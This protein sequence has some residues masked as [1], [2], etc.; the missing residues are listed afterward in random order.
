MSDSV[1]D[2][3]VA[4][5][6]ISPARRLRVQH[7]PFKAWVGHELNGYPAGVPLPAYRTGYHGLASQGRRESGD[8][9]LKR[10]VDLAKLGWEADLVLYSNGTFITG[11]LIS[12]V[13][14]RAALAE[15]IRSGAGAKPSS[16]EFDGVVAAAVAAEDPPPMM[17]ADG[18]MPEPRFVHLADVRT[19]GAKEP[20]APFMR[21]RLPAVSG[22]WIQP[23]TSNHEDR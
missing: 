14:F 6:W 16:A 18:D 9:L 13:K 11:H 19:L 7:E 5:A 22:F 17:D 1:W 21:L 10:L 8:P 4:A 15:S 3:S 23:R 12:G 20:C 2:G